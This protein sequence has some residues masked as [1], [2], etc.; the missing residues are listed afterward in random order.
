MPCR[1]LPV[2]KKYFLWHG[3]WLERQKNFLV[4]LAYYYNVLVFCPAFSNSRAGF[5]LVLHQ[6]HNHRQYIAIDSVKDF[7][8]LTRIKM[9]A[10]SSGFLTIDGVVSKILFRIKSFALKF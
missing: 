7:Y 10:K 9:K 2:T 4:E 6:H 8:E 1:L 5:N 3:I